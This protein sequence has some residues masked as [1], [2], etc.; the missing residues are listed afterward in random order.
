[1]KV[2]LNRDIKNL[3]KVG[4]VVIVKDGYGRNF[5]LKKQY[6]SVATK[7]SLSVLEKKID[8]LKAENSKLAKQAEQ[9][10][11]LLNGVICNIVRQA[12][13]DNTIY[14][15]VR[16]RDVFVFINDVLK[17]N[18]ISF[19]IDI[20]GIKFEKPIKMLGRYVIAVEIFGDI[21]ANVRLNLCRAQADFDNDIKS[22][23]KKR[24]QSLMSEKNSKTEET[25]NGNKKTE[26]KEKLQNKENVQSDTEKTK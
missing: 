2:I 21:V 12:A 24:E 10:S 13:D 4:D 17:K 11:E 25:N 6:A 22:F 1:M 18:N 14:G 9:I 16:V 15:S 5:L 3:G 26:D 19:K 8:E 7:S 23:D 20:C